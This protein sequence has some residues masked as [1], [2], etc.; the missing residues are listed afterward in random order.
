MWINDAWGD[1]SSVQRGILILAVCSEERGG[2]GAI[3]EP[4]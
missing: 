2:C 1:S 4:W 3:T